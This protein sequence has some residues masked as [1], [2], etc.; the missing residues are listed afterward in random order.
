M[1][2]SDVKDIEK[3][4]ESKLGSKL[5]VAGEVFSIILTLFMIWAANNV[6]SWNYSI[7]DFVQDSFAAVI[8]VID[9]TL[10]ISIITKIIRIIYQDNKTKSITQIVENLFSMLMIIIIFTIFPYNFQLLIN[11]SWINTA[12]KILMLIGLIGN[13]VGTITES[14]KLAKGS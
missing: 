10:G 8:W 3:E 14:A 13:F 4:V 5:K 9:I 11:L 7:F 12:V 1:K 6:L 2:T